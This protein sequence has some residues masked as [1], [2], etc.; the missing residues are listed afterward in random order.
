MCGIFVSTNRDTFIKLADANSN[1]GSYSHSIMDCSFDGTINYLRK[2]IGPV[3]ED[4]IP[5]EAELYIGHVQAPTSA[6]GFNPN[7]IHPA[8]YQNTRLY[9]NG[10]ILPSGMKVLHDTLK[11]EANWDTILLLEY[12]NKGYDLSEIDGSF[13]CCTINE[14]GIFVFRNAIAPLFYDKC[15]ISSVPF[16]GATML[17]HGKVYKLTETGLQESTVTFST[18]NNP[19]MI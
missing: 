15:T 11:N 7:N 2:E 18:K 19:Y 1:R 6:D 3:N 17:P 9:H 16:K 13:A 14:N 10:I 4:S 12:F 5:V 8:V